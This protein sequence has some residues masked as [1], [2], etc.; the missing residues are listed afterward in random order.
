MG[1]RLWSGGVK[2]LVNVGISR[3]ETFT[4]S[5]LC[6]YSLFHTIE[7]VPR[8]YTGNKIAAKDRAQGRIPTVVFS[9]DQSD[10]NKPVSRKQLL[11]TERKQIKS[12]LETVELPFFCSTRFKLQIRAGSGSSHLLDSGT[13][14]P[15]KVHRDPETGR[16]LNLV[17]QWAEDGVKG[18]KVNIPLVFKGEDI[19]PGLEKGGHLQKLETHLKCECS[20]ELIPP[21]IEVDISKLDIG[22]KLHLK[23]IGV[24][25]SLKVLS[26][27]ANLPI[28]KIISAQKLENN[29]LKMEANK[30][31][32]EAKKLKEE[33][34]KLKEAEPA[35]I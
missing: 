7:A 30:L 21:K 27:M 12:I 17:L 6:F 13:V 10:P 18:L 5:R 2:K 9:K 20:A 28:C 29:K 4:S 19:S 1:S 25:P 31:K 35:V 8:E 26:K 34:N 24:D 11:T 23:D 16:I 14:L 3:G 33:A 22:D 15:I 32:W